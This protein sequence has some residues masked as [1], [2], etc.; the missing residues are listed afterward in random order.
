MPISRSNKLPEISRRN[1][2][3]IIKARLSRRDL[4]RMGLITSAGY[5]V[6]KSGLSAW[7]DTCNPG[8]C[9]P[10]CSPPTLPFV[11][12]IPFPPLPAGAKHRGRPGVHVLAAD[13]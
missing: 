9:K 7:A 11:D 2:Q 1:R 5:L 8:E 10:G 13:G 4:F 12:P 6:H 3:E